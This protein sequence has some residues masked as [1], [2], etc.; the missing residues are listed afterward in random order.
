MGNEMTTGIIIL[1]VV[2]VVTLLIML[3]ARDRRRNRTEREVLHTRK[4]R[5]RMVIGGLLGFLVFEVMGIFLA[6][7]NGVFLHTDNRYPALPA[8]LGVVVLG[9][10]GVVIGVLASLIGKPKYGNHV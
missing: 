1:S 5:K 3:N 6:Y 2:T 4:Y 9:W 7:N 10:F 8:M